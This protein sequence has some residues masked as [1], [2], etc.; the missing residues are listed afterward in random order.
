MPIEAGWCSDLAMTMATG[1]DEGAMERDRTSRWV[2]SG[3]AGAKP[4]L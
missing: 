3:V 2:A 1:D 4:A